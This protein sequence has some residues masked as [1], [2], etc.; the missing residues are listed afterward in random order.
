MLVPAPPRSLTPQQWIEGME[1]F[2]RI[3]AGRCPTWFQAQP[4]GCCGPAVPEWAAQAAAALGVRLQSVAQP[5]QAVDA[6]LL[7]RCGLIPEQAAGG[8]AAAAP[9][10]ARGVHPF[11]TSMTGHELPAGGGFPGLRWQAAGSGART[12]VIWNAL[13]QAAELLQGLA[14][15]L[16]PG[17]RVITWEIQA[18]REDSN[19]PSG[20]APDFGRHEVD[21][22]RILEAERCASLDL[23]GWC[24]GGKAA[25]RFAVRHPARVRSL[26]IFHGAFRQASD[27]RDW[28][29]PWEQSMSELADR[30]LAAP[31]I[32]GFAAAA[33]RDFDSRAAL[34]QQRIARNPAAAAEEALD[35][36]PAAAESHLRRTWTDGASTRNYLEALRGF[37]AAAVP[38][39]LGAL[40]APVLFVSSERDRIASPAAA[41]RL[42][43]RIPGAGHVLVA[44]GNHHTPWEEPELAA[45]ILLDALAG[46]D[47]AGADRPEIVPYAA[48]AVR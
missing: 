40:Q 44:G 36:L 23:V 6:L 26:T 43:R 4:L 30:V 10:P 20:A 28:N 16:P 18:R 45:G 5:L 9:A 11:R 25:L 19:L 1:R 31:D 41:E 32:A 47:P 14:A 29:T 15:G 38:E 33:L 2:V 22:L 48:E 46:R 27:P 37:W 3:V 7:R 13:G 12:V 34:T 24:T 39:E 8:S 42:R 21:L 35:L 17:F